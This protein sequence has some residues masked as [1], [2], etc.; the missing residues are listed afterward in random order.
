MSKEIFEIPLSPDD[1]QKQFKNKQAGKHGGGFSE[2][3]EDRLNINEGKETKEL[4]WYSML[5]VV[6]IDGRW[7]QIVG[8]LI[9]KNEDRKQAVHYLDDN[10]SAYVQFNDYELTKQLHSHVSEM[11]RK[12]ELSQA[13]FKYVHWDSENI[14]TDLAKNVTVFGEFEKKK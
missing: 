3:L 8:G 11:L 9:D 6:K 13:E 5:D 7:A 12:G 4:P 14:G 1:F 10:S 2:K